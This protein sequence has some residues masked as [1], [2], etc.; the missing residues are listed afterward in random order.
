[1]LFNQVV[2]KSLTEYKSSIA[3]HPCIVS[4][5]P[6]GRSGS[7]VVPISDMHLSKREVLQNR[8]KLYCAP[9][10]DCRCI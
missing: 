7:K 2:L 6:I 10:Q 4:Q 5:C 1:M 9:K 3:S 8:L